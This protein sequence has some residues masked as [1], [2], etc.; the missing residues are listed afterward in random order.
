MAR[1]AETEART[2][3]FAAKKGYVDDLS[4]LSQVFSETT[5]PTLPYFSSEIETFIGKAKD[6]EFVTYYEFMMYADRFRHGGNAWLGAL[7]V[8]TAI[9]WD[10]ALYDLFPADN[11]GKTF[12][13]AIA[14]DSRMYRRLPDGYYAHLTKPNNVGS[15]TAKK[16]TAWASYLTDKAGV[17]DKTMNERDLKVKRFVGR[18]RKQF[19]DLPSIGERSG[20]VLKNNLKLEYRADTDGLL[21]TTL[22]IVKNPYIAEECLDTFI[23]MVK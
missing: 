1:A 11:S 23:S 22:S 3:T 18:L 21:S 12:E 20:K 8:K 6:V 17:Y 4:V 9:K 10:G 14:G 19:G 13:F 7:S 16:M 5:T 15:M 2:V